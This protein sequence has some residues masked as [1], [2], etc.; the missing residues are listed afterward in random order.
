M[1]SVPS[2]VVLDTTQSKA[3]FHPLLDAIFR[4]E[5]PNNVLGDGNWRLTTK[6][7][8]ADLKLTPV[9]VPSEVLFTEGF[10]CEAFL[11]SHL[12][13]VCKPEAFVFF[14]E[15]EADVLAP[16]F[17]TLVAGTQAM[18]GPELTVL[19]RNC[20]SAS[21]NP[22]CRKAIDELTQ[23]FFLEFMSQ[24]LSKDESV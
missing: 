14:F 5:N 12:D 19:F 22:K 24:D 20:E 21:M 9:H 18:F 13:E 7:F 23:N 3:T 2:I 15:S 11:T 6:Y 1:Q 10:D 16:N 8:T 17:N 4:R